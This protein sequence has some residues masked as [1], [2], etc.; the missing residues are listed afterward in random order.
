MQTHFSWMARAYVAGSVLVTATIAALDPLSQHRSV[1]TEDGA[2]GLLA[3]GMLACTALV[4]LIDVFLNDLLPP[5]YSLRCAHLHRHIVFMVLAIGQVALAF[6][7]AR[8]GFARPVVLRYLF[9]ALAAASIA[10]VGVYQ[11]YR[12][13]K[14]GG[15]ASA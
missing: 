13:A 3:V 6:V 14:R 5:R 15:E 2:G 7:E 8:D 9:D 10:C 4:A 12:Q 1:M 11:H